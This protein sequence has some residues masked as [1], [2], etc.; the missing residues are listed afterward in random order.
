M[1]NRLSKGLVLGLVLMLGSSMAFATDGYF[2]LGYGTISSGFA[3]AGTAF[4]ETSLIG[5]N[6]AGNVFNSNELSFGIGLFNPNRQ[7]TIT[8]QPSGSP[9]FGLMPGTVKSDSKLF[10]MPNIGKNWKLNDNNALTLSIYGNGGMN[11]N[12]PTQTFYDQSAD[13][14]GVNLMQMYVDLAYS[15]KL[16][17]KHSLGISALLGAQ[18]FEAKGLKTFGDYG[19][20]SD[21]NKLTGKGT[22]YSAGL[23]FKIGYMGELFNGFWLGAKYQ[24]K[25]YMSAFK[26]YAGLFAEHGKFEIPSNWSVGVAYHLCSDF[27]VLADVKQI[28]YT[29]SKSVSNPMFNQSGTMN[30]LGSDNGAGF[31]WKDM[32]IYKVGFNYTGIDTWTLRAG[33]SYGKQPIPASEVMFNILAPAVNESHI[34]LGFSKKLNEKGNALNFAFNYALNNKVT[35]PNPMDPAQTIDLEMNQLYFEIGFTF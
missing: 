28:N 20:S 18:S 10:V 27:T 34:A 4:Y 22:D 1:K 3:G 8:G 32:T 29:S 9:Y 2:S 25:I 17:E 16:G 30:Q 7:Y 5:G 19:Y 11:T 23:G 26:D 21:P 24:S 6:P 15:F 35:G 33:Y 31:G 12:Y 13:H 14:T